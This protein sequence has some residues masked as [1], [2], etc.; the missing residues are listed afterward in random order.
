MF[1]A[2]VEQLSI[3]VCWTLSELLVAKSYIWG[4]VRR[5]P[6]LYTWPYVG[7]TERISCIL[8]PSIKCTVCCYPAQ[9]LV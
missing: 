6:G 4:C 9:C 2:F 7:Q 8:L 3:V 1:M 5:W